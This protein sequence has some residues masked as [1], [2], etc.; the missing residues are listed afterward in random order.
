MRIS[1]FFGFGWLSILTVV[2]CGIGINL[3]EGRIVLVLY[4]PFVI[5]AVYMTTRFRL[6]TLEPWRRVHS[7]AMILYSEL[8]EQEYE[9]AKKE[10]REFDILTPCRGLAE[11]L[12]G[13]SEIDGASL[14][15]DENRKS[16]YKALV[17]SYPQA[18]LQNISPERHAA[19]L[20]GVNRDIETSKLGPDILIA[21]AIEQKH[22][23]LLAAK[24]FHAL[25][26]GKVK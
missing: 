2:V 11:Q 1:W 3:L 15:S 6:Y 5:V 19:V 20:D 25:L 16:Y 13:Q 17:E 9:T 14:L 8:A 4:V 26:I 24:Y 10:N 18:F 23:R 21:H 12:F 7:K 22:N